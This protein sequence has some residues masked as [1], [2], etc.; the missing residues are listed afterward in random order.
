MAQNLQL[1]NLCGTVFRKGN[2]VFTSDGN[3]LLS[4]VG[5]RIT[6]FNLIENTTVTLPFENRRNIRRLALSPDN[7]LLVSIDIEGQAILINLARRVLLAHFGFGDVVRDIAFSP[8]GKYIAAT[9][10]RQVQLWRAPSVER[11]FKPLELVRVFSGNYDDTTTVSWSSDSKFILVGCKAMNVKMF[12][13][14]NTKHFTPLTMS[15]GHRAPIIGAFFGRDP[16]FVYTLSKCGVL[17]VWYWN[18]NTENSDDDDDEP[19]TKRSRVQDSDDKDKLKTKTKSVSKNDAKSLFIAKF[20][21]LVLQ[22]KHF[23]KKDHQ[24]VECVAFNRER[25]MLVVGLESGVFSLYELPTTAGSSLSLIHSLSVSSQRIT[26]VGIN[27]SGEWLALGCAKLGQ[28]VVWEWQSESYVLKQQGHSTDMMCLS[29]S[30]DGQTVATGGRDA[31]VKLWNAV[32]GLCYVTFSDHSQAVTSVQMAHNKQALFSASLDG[33]VRAYDLIRYRLFRTFVTPEP[34]QLTHVAADPSGEIV[35]ATAQDTFEIFVWSVQT[36]N[37]VDVLSGHE[38]PVSCIAFN[39]I[40]G[41]L[42]SSSWDKTVRVWSVFEGNKHSTEEWQ[43]SSDVLW[44]AWSPDG[45]QLC[46]ATLDGQLWF[47]DSSSGNV[48]DSIDCRHD[49]ETGRRQIDM[50]RQSIVRHFSYVSYSVDGSMVLAGGHSK[51]VCLYSATDDHN[52]LERFQISHNLSLDGV[53]DKLNSTNE[54]KALAALSSDSDAEDIRKRSDRLPGV[55]TGEF[56]SRRVVPTVQAMGVQMSPSGNGFSVVSSEGLLVYGNDQTFY[57]DPT[58]LDIEC[59]VQ[60]IHKAI[61]K[62]Q[63]SKAL[64][65]SMRL[66]EEDLMEIAYLAVRPADIPSVVESFPEVFV[67]RLLDFITSHLAR[68]KQF[69]LHL[70]WCHH[71]LFYKGAY[72]RSSAGKLLGKLRALHKTLASFD[73]DLSKICET[74]MYTMKYVMEMQAQ[75]ARDKPLDE[76]MVD[77]NNSDD[78]DGSS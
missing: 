57:F 7:V 67:D 61:Q 62:G 70:R 32:T 18:R 76:V 51:Y 23:V 10:R 54:Q 25:N 24:K 77:G 14:H 64:V 28:L 35:C 74:N 19:N 50:S 47:W 46:S 30:A 2:I 53:V 3:S 8:N 73:H 37:L 43:H 17:N 15:G 78:N 33:T 44:L 52:M 75:I 38:G 26:T 71:L 58:D 27:A 65:M 55:T 16:E 39:P 6:M 22:D 29:Y 9:H 60:N 45:S 11:Q 13:V 68:T 1:T 72:I 31:K 5:N 36:G 21:R 48:I 59:T 66:N 63:N 40:N 69:E 12:A 49:A 42:A 41:K 20:G 34:A 56:S 4:P